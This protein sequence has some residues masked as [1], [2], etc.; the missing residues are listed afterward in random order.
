M[1]QTTLAATAQRLIAKNGRSVTLRKESRTPKDQAKPWRGTDCNDTD[2][3]VTAVI[4][5]YTEADIDGE[6][7]KRGDRRAL[8]ST[9]TDIR[10]WDLMIDGDEH[11]RIQNV[12]QI[13]PGSVDILWKLQLRN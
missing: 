7:I 10:Q 5:D 3:T 11:Y 4:V 13:K 12:E 2:I 9:T 8:V 1:S 6:R